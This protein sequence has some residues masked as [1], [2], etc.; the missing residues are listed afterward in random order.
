MTNLLSAGGDSSQDEA[1]EEAKAIT[2]GLHM[3]SL[4]ST[5]GQSPRLYVQIKYYPPGEICSS[6]VR[7]GSAEANPVIRV[8][9]E[10]AGRGALGS[11]A[12]PWCQGRGSTRHYTAFLF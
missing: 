7:A 1:E 4:T 3:H 5:H 8:P 9:S 2:V 6:R 12:L 10:E 11:P